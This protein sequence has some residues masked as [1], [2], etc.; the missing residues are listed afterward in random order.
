MSDRITTPS[1]CRYPGCSGR[2]FRAAA[3]VFTEAADFDI[4][5]AIEF[6]LDVAIRNAHPDLPVIYAV[7]FVS[8][9]LVTTHAA[10]RSGSGNLSEIAGS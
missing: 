3:H 5:P 6:V 9:S 8:Y 10:L 4:L 2:A 1:G 7:I